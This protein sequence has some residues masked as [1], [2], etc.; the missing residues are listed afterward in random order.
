[1]DDVF[2][3]GSSS[4]REMTGVANREEECVVEVHAFVEDSPPNDRPG[5]GS[6][7]AFV[8]AIFST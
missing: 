5:S 1:M 6:I 3:S 4:I 2:P 8:L 7:G